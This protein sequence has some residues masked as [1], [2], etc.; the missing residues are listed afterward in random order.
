MFDNFITLEVIDTGHCG[1]IR[2]SKDVKFDTFNNFL[3]PD[4]DTFPS[5]ILTPFSLDID[6]APV[7]SKPG[8][9]LSLT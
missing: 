3:R 5:D 1:K 7:W 9:G 6:P 8:M 4:P 2:Q